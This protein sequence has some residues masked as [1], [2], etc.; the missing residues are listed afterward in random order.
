LFDTIKSKYI[1]FRHYPEKESKPE[2]LSGLLESDDLL[3]LP[4]RETRVMF[5]SGKNTLV[6]RPFFDET[7]IELFY[8]F[9]LG[10]DK[11]SLLHY[12]LLPE[13][14]IFNIFSYPEIAHSKLK[15]AFPKFEIWHR[16]SPFIENIVIDS[17]RWHHSKAHVYIH[18]GILDIG[19]AHMKK[20]EFFNTFNF[21]EHSD[22]VYFILN[23]LEQF[24]LSASTTEVHISTDSE[25]HEEIFD[26]IRNYVQHIKL[27]RPSEK[28][29]YSYVFD[30]FQL[31]R[32]ANLFNLG[33]CGL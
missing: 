14:S 5:E 18:K 30:E 1:A 2:N 6:P 4:Y 11:C 31:A 13:A 7:K 24:N 21:K 27:I 28:F 8:N 29:T 15:K 9:N 23:I 19:V 25:N 33:L 26:Y 16:T 17:A 22:I 32:F 10:E 20:L 12:N 3:K